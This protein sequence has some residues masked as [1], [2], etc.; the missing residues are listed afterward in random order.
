M[1]SILEF[2]MTSIVR[3][4]HHTTGRQH[5]VWHCDMHGRGTHS[6]D[7][8]KLPGWQR[9]RRCAFGDPGFRE[10]GRTLRTPF[11]AA[12]RTMVATDGLVK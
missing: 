7:I 4:K 1:S 3:R 6:G 8:A 12:I 11:A 9:I 10:R 2:Q 5:A